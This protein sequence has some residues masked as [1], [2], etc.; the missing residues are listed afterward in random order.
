MPGAPADTL[1]SE[2]AAG[3]TRAASRTRRQPVIIVHIGDGAR[4]MRQAGVAR[5]MP[6]GVS[7]KRQVAEEDGI[8]VPGTNY[9]VTADDRAAA[10]DR[11]V[12]GHER[13]HQLA[14]GAYAGSG[15]QLTTRRGPD[16]R[17]YAVGGRIKADLS[18]VPG[19]PEATL[20]KANAVRRAAL[21]PASPSAAD[22]RVA[23]EAYRLAQ[24][25]KED[26]QAQRTAVLA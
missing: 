10:V 1:G 20:R 5:E 13:L 16:G 22:M 26:M 4:R 12:R 18:R 24:S 21:A 7:G 23:A 17:S 2:R 6:G 11:N 3:D 8:P 25:A 9:V 14:L 15:V 19:N